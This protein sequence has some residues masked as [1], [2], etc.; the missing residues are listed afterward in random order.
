[1][2]SSVGFALRRLRRRPAYA[3]LCVLTLGIGIGVCLMAYAVIDAAVRNAVPFDPDNRLIWIGEGTAEIDDGTSLP[4][5]R[6]WRE[7]SRT[8]VDVTALT[9]RELRVTSDGQSTELPVAYVS[10]QFFPTLGVLPRIGR[11]FS[12]EDD[13]RHATPVVIVSDQF[14]RSNLGGR[15]DA[16]GQTLLIEAR[17]HIIVGVMPPGFVFPR[18]GT[19]AW[20]PMLQGLGSFETTERVRIVEAVGRL[21]ID[22]TAD[23]AREDLRRIAGTELA[24]SPGGGDYTLLVRSLREH[25]L[26]QLLPRLRVLMAAGL[27]MLLLGCVNVGNMLV[28]QVL[29]R[30]QEF[31]VRRALG[32]GRGHD[33]RLLLAEAG[34]LLVGGVVVGQGLALTVVQLASRVATHRELPEFVGVSITP[35]GLGIGL[36]LAVVA[37]AGLGLVAYTQISSARLGGALKAATPGHA[38][39]RSGTRWRRTLTAVEV[40]LTLV[41]LLGAG[42][43]AKSYWALARRSLGFD[44][45]GVFVARVSR[46]H[47]VF[48]PE[49]R[50]KVEAFMARLI[51]SLKEEPGFEGAA[52]TTQAPASGNGIV[53]RLS[54]GERGDSVRVGVQAVSD[55]FFATLGLRVRQGRTFAPSDQLGAPVAVIDEELA[56]NAFHGRPPL[57]QTIVLADLALE[58][59]VVGVVSH[60][61]QGG[62]QTE[63]LT[64]VYLPYRALPLPWVTV[65]VRSSMT[66][67]AVGASLRRIVHAIDQEQPVAS[68]ALLS[69]MLADRLDRSRFYAFLVAACAGAS[70]L[71]TAIGLYGAVTLLVAQRTREFGVRMSLGASPQRICL[72]VVRE[73][74]I[75]VTGG[76]LLGGFLA[77]GTMRI[78]TALLYGISPLDPTVLI[79]AVSLVIGMSLL[80]SVV[81]AVRAAWISPATALRVE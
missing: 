51:A 13:R 7:N 17:L 8:L 50:P 58:A 10:W 66:P 78:L 25:V 31:A 34:V 81:P 16:I 61:R 45:R 18:D 52:I 24:R 55:G 5:V 67:G 76:L 32:G 47:V 37:A 65:L 29:H 15:G 40:A 2:T 12:A 79:L 64:Q 26:R 38:G 39:T 71:L 28:A 33:L 73:G 19:L 9:T 56:Q 70:T 77:F 69:E 36:L 21:R 59:R 75:S 4:L 6:R 41:L 30:Q 48:T 60:V 22:V 54:N 3:I 44:T 43:L 53:S 1:M 11:P 23:A 42:V 27:A 80:A 68:F 62:P 20:L 72:M 74:L 46:P 35:R 57:E 49:E 14:W 63:G